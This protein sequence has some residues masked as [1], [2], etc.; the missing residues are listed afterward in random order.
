M[1]HPSGIAYRGVCYDVGS[2]FATGQGDISRNVWNTE[3]MR[4]EISLIGDELNGNSVNIYGTDLDRLRE[5]TAFALERGLHVWLDP[6]YPDRS[7]DEVIDHLAEVARLA[8]S[9]RKQGGDIDVT[10]GALHTIYTPGLFPGDPYLQRIANIFFDGDNRFGLREPAT[11][12]EWLAP[13][14][15]ANLT[16]SAPRLNEF[17]ARAAGVARGIFHGRLGYS[18]TPWEQVDWSPFDLIGIVYFTMPSYMTRRQHL[19]FLAGYS[20]WDKPLFICGFGTASYQG[21]V[22]KGFFNWDIVDRDTPD[23]RIVDGPERDESVQAG[24]F[25]TMLS[26]YEEAGVSGTAPTDLVHPTHPHHPTD[27][28]R[29]LDMASMAIVK[30]IRDDYDNHDSGYRRE[31]KESF[32]AIA[33]FYGRTAEREN[34]A[35]A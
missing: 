6:R 1:T 4:A 23:L 17:L 28:S 3:L 34:R 19:D 24:Y 9:F 30:C 21:A 16:E 27:R 18:A 13:G 32:L 11:A 31:L 29:D 5:T 14:V 33:D 20:R 26:I 10:V 2:T 25:T 7:Q 12:A 8:E 22:E 15:T 35:A